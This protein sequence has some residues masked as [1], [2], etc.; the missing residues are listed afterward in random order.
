MWCCNLHVFM[1]L[2]FNKG[3]SRRGP[4]SYLKYF[5][6]FQPLC[7][8]RRHDS[9][10]DNMT[11]VFYK[12]PTVHVLI[13]PRHSSKYEARGQCMISSH[14][15]GVCCVFPGWHRY[16]SC[17]ESTKFWPL[18]LWLRP[19]YRKLPASPIM[20]Y[21]MRFWWQPRVQ[22]PLSL[23][24]GIWHL[25]IWGWDFGLGLVNLEKPTYIHTHMYVFVQVCSN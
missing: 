9:Y 7:R 25:R 21:S 4:I 12:Y 3:E 11:K 16:A 24:Y 18:S 2:N 10:R 5:Q 1:I 15:W 8:H 22:N 6:N 19:Q 23:Y 20:K 13:R 14:P 17:H